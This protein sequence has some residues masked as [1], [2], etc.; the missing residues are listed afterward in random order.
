MMP[1]IDNK[2]FSIRD[3]YLMIKKLLEHQWSKICI[4]AV[5]LDILSKIE[6]KT[7]IADVQLISSISNTDDNEALQRLEVLLGGNPSTM[8]PELVQ[9]GIL[10]G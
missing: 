8:K 4:H 3:A 1:S 5:C 9:K 2:V 7:E 6:E 10:E